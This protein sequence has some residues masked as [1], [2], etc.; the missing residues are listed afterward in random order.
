MLYHNLKNAWRYIIR[1]RI[2]SVV[3]IAGLALG[4]C[5]FLLLMEYISL[6][7]S[8]NIFH[9]NLPNMYRL[10][11][12]DPSGNS[13]PEVEPGWASIVEQRFPE[14]RSEEHTSELQ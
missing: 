12:E 10:I 14:V 13:W 1:N 6:Q 11:N 5:A 7:K 2:S 9:K 4:L 8:A 3:N